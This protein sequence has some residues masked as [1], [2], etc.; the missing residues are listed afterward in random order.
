[1]FR[2]KYKLSVLF[3]LLFVAACTPILKEVRYTGGYPGHVLDK[4]TFDVSRSKKLVLLRATII[5]AMAADMGRTTVSGQDSDSFAKLLAGASQ[6]INYAAADIYGTSTEACIASNPTTPPETDIGCRGFQENFETNLPR[7]EGRIIKVMLAALP[8]D[9]A[10]K[11]LDQVAKGNV[12]GAAWSAVGAVAATGGGFHVAFARYRSGLE[13]VAGAL[14]QC[15]GGGTFSADESTVV[16]AAACLG[17]SEEN[18]FE[19]PRELG[20][21]DLKLAKVSRRAFFMLLRGVAADCVGLDFSGKGSDLAASQDIRAKACN[22]IGFEPTPRPF[23]IDANRDIVA[24]VATGS[25]PAAPPGYVSAL[26]AAVIAPAIVAAGE[27]PAQV[28]APPVAP[29]VA[30][31]PAVVLPPGAP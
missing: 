29:P 31:T 18:L 3:Y 13:T 22:S 5:L 2:E 10:R 15:R 12:M 28:A 27:P 30:G 14:P 16:D 19:N 17:L 11:F 20:R 7:I 24:P 26:A 9:K 4:R 6:E 21:E 25:A 23:R 8:T 1:M